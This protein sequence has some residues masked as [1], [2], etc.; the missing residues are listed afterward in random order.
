MD[1]VEDRFPTRT[2]RVN[3]E[4]LIRGFSRLPRVL[5]QM[6]YSG[7]RAGQD[8]AVTNIMGSRDTICILPT[9]TGKTAVFV[10]PTLCLEWHTLVFSPLVALMRDQVQG[11]QRMGIKAGQ[12]SG[13]QSEAENNM[14]IRAWAA[15]NLDL[16]Y[17]APERLGNPMFMQGIEAVRPDLV[18]LDEAHTLSAW[19][20]NFRPKYKVVGDFIAQYNPKCVA[21]LTA[22][23]PGE[24][25]QDIRDVLGLHGAQKLIYYPRRTNLHLHTRDYT[26]DFDI[27]E[28]VKE[29]RKGGAVLIYCATIKK[30][31]QLAAALGDQL[32]MD[33]GFY[34][35]ELPDDVKRTNLDLFMTGRV[36]IMV[37][38]NAFG[39]GVDKPNIRLV[40]HRDLPG[41]VEALQQEI[42]RA[43]RDGLDSMCITL[44]ATDAI[45]TQQFFI[46]NGHPKQEEIEAVFAAY[47]K[48][49]GPDGV[50]SLTGNEIAK[51]AGVSSFKVDACI[52]IL[53]ANQVIEDAQATEK[54]ARVKFVGSS[55][56]DRFKKWREDLEKNGFMRGDEFLEF[57]LN[58]F[59]RRCGLGYS[60]VCSYLRDWDKQ[61][62]IRY[63]SPFRGKSRKVIGKPHLIDFPRLQLKAIDAQRKLRDVMKYFSVPDEEK[64]AYLEEYFQVHQI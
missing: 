21:A 56:V 46:N 25:E 14:A 36:N 57:D 41:S 1:T 42:G 44:R 6:G 43:G 49:K 38:T 52:S 32:S 58:A 29:H 26:N 15:G 63:V 8:A 37:A 64:H 39:M 3:K 30:V 55:E 53:V 7:M 40:L 23:A 2:A 54:I 19:S 16:L 4:T 45:N 27:G 18:V 51:I 10:I 24:V 20:D 22:T 47:D 5:K 59:V 61:D 17:V 48:S 11:L 9:S 13:M 35:G 31:E 28:L 33:V 62:L 60:T 50:V 12:M 34:H